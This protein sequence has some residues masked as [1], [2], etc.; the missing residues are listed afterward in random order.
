MRP[1]R[2]LTADAGHALLAEAVRERHAIIPNRICAVSLAL[3]E[4]LLDARDRVAASHGKPRHSFCPRPPLVSTVATSAL[5]L[6]VTNCRRRSGFAVMG[7]GWCS[8][9]ASGSDVRLGL[10]DDTAR[11]L[12]CVRE[13]ST[14]GCDATTGFRSGRPPRSPEHHRTAWSSPALSPGRRCRS[15]P[16]RCAERASGKRC[17][18]PRRAARSPLAR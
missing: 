14:P 13:R 17:V 1:P 16:D 15:S 18:V 3:A 4:L 8:P 9:L 2:V 10:A 7:A 12:A 6:L 11:A 5:F